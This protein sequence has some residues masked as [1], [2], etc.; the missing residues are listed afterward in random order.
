MK[1][2]PIENSYSFYPSNGFNHN[3]YVY[4]INQQMIV[5]AL[6]FA[7]TYSDLAKYHNLNNTIGKNDSLSCDVLI[8]RE[9]ISEYVVFACEQSLDVSGKK[10]TIKISFQKGA[11]FDLDAFEQA[12]YRYFQN[13]TTI[14]LFDIDDTLNAYD[15]GEVQ[16]ML[17]N[18]DNST[19]IF[20]QCFLPQWIND[21]TTI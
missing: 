15:A 17:Q 1:I 10:Q 19:D 7:Q 4:D 11:V 14:E 12:A 5:P 21:L 20:V 16:L 6:S 3:H 18:K 8:I 13:N 9:T 2:Y